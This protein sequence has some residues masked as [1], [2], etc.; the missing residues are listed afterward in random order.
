MIPCYYYW[1]DSTQWIAGL[2]KLHD[3]SNK[4]TADDV[5]AV[6]KTNANRVLANVFAFCTHCVMGTSAL[7]LF[8]FIE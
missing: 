6:V 1:L 8:S 5:E 4:R 2:K 7:L 3:N